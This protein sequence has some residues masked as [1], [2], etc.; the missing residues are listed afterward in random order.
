MNAKF[1]INLMI[2]LLLIFVLMIQ[3][4]MS[5][6]LE[7]AQRLNVDLIE[8]LKEV[9]KSQGVSIQ[10]MELLAELTGALPQKKRVE[11]KSP[12]KLI[13]VPDEDGWL[14]QDK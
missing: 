7:A 12:W 6:K 3:V 13:A 9:T 8:T 10:A 1:I 11:R 4:E 14:R 2:F 5:R